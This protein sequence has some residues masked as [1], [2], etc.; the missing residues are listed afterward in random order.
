MPMSEA[1]WLEKTLAERPPLTQQQVSRLRPILAPTTPHMTAAP[2]AQ[3]GA[4]TEMTPHERKPR[5]AQR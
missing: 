1:T 3:A 2:A 4:A 5:N